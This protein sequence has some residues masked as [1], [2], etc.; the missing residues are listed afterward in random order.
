LLLFGL[1]LCY[2]IVTCLALFVLFDLFV[3]VIVCCDVGCL[4]C[5][6]LLFC[7]WVFDLLI[8]CDW[9]AV[10]CDCVFLM[11]NSVVTL[12]AV[13]FGWFLLGFVLF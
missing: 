5:V 10:L 6:C 7:S 11:F 2:L 1:F 12:F 3:R 8:L 13:L 9:I 4:H